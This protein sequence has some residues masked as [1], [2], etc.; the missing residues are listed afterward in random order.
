MIHRCKHGLIEEQCSYCRNMAKRR[1]LRKNT[2]EIEE[3]PERNRK[4]A[5]K[6][7]SSGS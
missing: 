4:Q 3:A 2:S 6:L 1:Q 7:K 5:D